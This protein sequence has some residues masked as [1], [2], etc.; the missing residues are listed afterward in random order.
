MAQGKRGLA[1]K[2]LTNVAKMNG[3]K[4]AQELVADL[5]AKVEEKDEK[6]KEAEEEEEEEATDEESHSILSAFKYPKL[7]KNILLVLFVW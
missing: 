2:Q 3:R 7:R 1:Q 4:N 6:K 5:V